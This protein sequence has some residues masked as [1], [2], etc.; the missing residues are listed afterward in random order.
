MLREPEQA[1]RRWSPAFLRGE[2]A[3]LYSRFTVRERRLP[4]RRAHDWL[5]RPVSRGSSALHA[6]GFCASQPYVASIMSQNIA[7]SITSQNID[8]S[9]TSST[10]WCRV[11]LED[12]FLRCILQSLFLF[13]HL[14]VRVFGAQ[15][16]IHGTE[17]YA[18]VTLTT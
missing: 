6:K 9:F 15:R 10:N 7:A 13:S 8:A 11:W 17:S 18:L 16:N 3:R 4:Q 14:F 1:G 5:L 2:L 12:F